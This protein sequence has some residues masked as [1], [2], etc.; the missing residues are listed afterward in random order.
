MKDVISKLHAK[1]ALAFA[2]RSKNACSN[3]YF[4]SLDLASSQ[5]ADIKYEPSEGCS[6]PQSPIALNNSGFK[7]KSRKPVAWIPTY[8]PFLSALLL[9][10][11]SPSVVVVEGWTAISSESE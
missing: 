4:S 8:E 3:N 6:K 7:R 11:A 5:L 10:E 1:A 9:L 2:A